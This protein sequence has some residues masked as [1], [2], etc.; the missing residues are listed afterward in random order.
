MM[1]E[2]FMWGFGIIG[3]ILGV[4]QLG[5]LVMFIWMAFRFIGAQE[6]MADSLRMIAREMHR[7]NRDQGGSGGQAGG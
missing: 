1:F 4:I 2:E 5:L 3:I 6:S 7:N